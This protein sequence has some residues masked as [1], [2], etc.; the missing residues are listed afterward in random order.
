M[1]LQDTAS[2]EREKQWLHWGVTTEEKAK[3]YFLTDMYVYACVF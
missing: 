2:T 3:K 1:L